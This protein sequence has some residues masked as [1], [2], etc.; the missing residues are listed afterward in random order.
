M[1][2]PDMRSF[3]VDALSNR[4]RHRSRAADAGGSGDTR[5]GCDR[6]GLELRPDPD[7]LPISEVRDEAG[8][9]DRRPKLGN[10]DQR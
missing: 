4:I 1:L 8:S 3:S 7:V 10:S 2:M 5:H 6:G 9:L